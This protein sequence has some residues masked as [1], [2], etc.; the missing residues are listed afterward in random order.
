MNSL[1]MMAVIVR[2]AWSESRPASEQ[3]RGSSV[4]D[5]SMAPALAFRHPSD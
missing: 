1:A 5:L 2:Q 4:R 3:Q